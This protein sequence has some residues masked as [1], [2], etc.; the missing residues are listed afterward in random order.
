MKAVCI[1]ANNYCVDILPNKGRLDLTTTPVQIGSHNIVG[2]SGS[3]FIVY[4]DVTQ[5]SGGVEVLKGTSW[6]LSLWKGDKFTYDGST[7]ALNPVIAEYNCGLPNKEG[8]CKTVNAYN[9]ATC[10]G[11][12]AALL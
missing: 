6:K 3:D 4:D 10:S 2:V 1:R 12:N 9:A 8:Y 5:S 7:W 11:C